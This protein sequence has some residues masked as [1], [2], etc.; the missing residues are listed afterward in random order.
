MT[1]AE[2]AGEMGPIVNYANDQAITGRVG[3]YPS[4][5]SCNRVT[6]D[7]NAGRVGWERFCP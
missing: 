5:R 4:P 3:I 7:S 2:F 6:A 1:A